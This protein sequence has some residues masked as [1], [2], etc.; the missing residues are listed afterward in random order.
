M[1]YDVRG[2]FPQ[3]IEELRQ[4]FK[5]GSIDGLEL[6]KTFIEKIAP[7][8][9]NLFNGFEKERDKRILA[10]W[11]RYIES[12]TKLVNG[13]TTKKLD[14][15]NIEVTSIYNSLIRAVNKHEQDYWE[16]VISTVIKHNNKEYE[17]LM[18]T[19]PEI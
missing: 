4:D 3:I 18:K 8:L 12:V 1:V 7:K 16:T 2:H 10:E 9:Q 5:Q 17:E 11:K 13:D 19:P 6:N 15:F 14:D